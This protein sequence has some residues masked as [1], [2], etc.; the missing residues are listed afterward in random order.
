M[1]SCAV[2]VRINHLGHILNIPS[3]TYNA[4]V[5]HC[6]KILGTTCSHPVTWN[7]KTIILYDDFVRGIHEG[8]LFENN[9][10]TLFEYD[11]SGN[12]EKVKYQGVWIMVDN[13]YLDCSTTISPMKH[14]VT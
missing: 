2:W 11:A 10:F 7:D 1:L 5:T 13:G 8:K 4:T 12:I 6:R 14:S 3:Y 9:E